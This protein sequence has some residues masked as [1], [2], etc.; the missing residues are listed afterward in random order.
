[1][2]ENLLIMSSDLSLNQSPIGSNISFIPLI[3]SAK[4]S[5]MPFRTFD[6]T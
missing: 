5:I 6:I 4:N 3:N 1:M 2:L